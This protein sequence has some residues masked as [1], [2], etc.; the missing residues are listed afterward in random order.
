MQSFT[1]RAAKRRRAL[2]D[3]SELEGKLA[4]LVEDVSIAL[5]NG[6]R[7]GAAAASSAGRDLGQDVEAFLVPHLNDVAAQV[8]SIIQKRNEGIYTD[9]TTKDLLASEADAVKVL[10]ETMTTLAVFEVQTIL[11]AIISAL[12]A[13]VNAAVGFALLA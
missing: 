9:A 5:Q 6:A 1:V 12:A 3:F 2:S 11:N 4:T 7:A 13:A 8:V 10:L